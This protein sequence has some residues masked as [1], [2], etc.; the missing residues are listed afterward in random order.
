MPEGGTLNIH[1]YKEANDIII[2][3][4]DTGVGIPEKTKASCLLHFLRLKPKV[5]DSAYL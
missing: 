1:A 2:A 3:V 4:K 5:K